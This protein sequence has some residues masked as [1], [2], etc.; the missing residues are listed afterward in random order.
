MA[1]LGC[2]GLSAFWCPRCGDCTCERAR[3]GECC[4]D[5]KDCPLHREDSRHAETVS[6]DECRA[7]VSALARD[8]G[9][10]LTTND[11]EAVSRFAQYLFERSRKEKRG[12]NAD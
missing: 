10:E 8:Q 9:V 6:L 7:K 5:G 3:D 2:T 1:D 4:F 11:H 12:P